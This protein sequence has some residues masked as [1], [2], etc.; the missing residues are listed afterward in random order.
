M[1]GDK[2]N[3]FTTFITLDSSEDSGSDKSI[4]D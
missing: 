1:E 2:E 4:E 3:Q